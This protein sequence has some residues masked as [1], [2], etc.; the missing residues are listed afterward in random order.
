M[1]TLLI[2]DMLSKK[3]KIPL[4]VVAEPL[5]LIGTSSSIRMEQRVTTTPS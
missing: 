1:L 5:T 3:K 4:K 2:D